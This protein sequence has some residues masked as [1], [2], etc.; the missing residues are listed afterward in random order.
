M[1]IITS[2]KYTHIYNYEVQVPHFLITYHVQ[3]SIIL[4]IYMDIAGSVFSLHAAILS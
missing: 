1:N 3:I 4:A 2:Y